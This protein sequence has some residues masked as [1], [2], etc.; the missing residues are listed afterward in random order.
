LPHEDIS[1]RDIAKVGSGLD[2]GNETA[3]DIVPGLRMGNFH[4]SDNSLIIYKH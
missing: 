1:R 2:V 4:G 3:N